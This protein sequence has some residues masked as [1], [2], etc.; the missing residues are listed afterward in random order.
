MRPVLFTS[1]AAP[2]APWLHP[3]ADSRQG[4]RAAGVPAPVEIDG[5]KPV[6]QPVPWQAL[7]WSG[8]SQQH[9]RGSLYSHS[10][11]TGAADRVQPAEQ[12]AGRVA[13]SCGLGAGAAAARLLQGIT[14]LAAQAAD[15]GSGSAGYW[16]SAEAGS[17]RPAAP[18]DGDAG[19]GPASR[20]TGY[21]S[22]LRGYTSSAPGLQDF[23][24]HAAD[25]GMQEQYA[26][27][28]RPAQPVRVV[29]LKAQSLHAG[30]D[31]LQRQQ[32][33]QAPWQLHGGHE[34]LTL[35]SQHGSN[36][37]GQQQAEA[38]A[39]VQQQGDGIM[40]QQRHQQQQQRQHWEVTLPRSPVKSPRKHPVGRR[41]AL[42]QRLKA[43]N[44]SKAAA[45]AGTEAGGGA[46]AGLHHD[47]AAQLIAQL[48]ELMQ[49]GVGVGQQGSTG[50]AAAP[51]AVTGSGGSRPD[52]DAAA[53]M[54][55]L[56]HLPS[57]PQGPAKQQVQS[58]EAQQ[59][60]QQQQQ[61][62]QGVE[63]PVFREGGSVSQQVPGV[64]SCHSQEQ[65]DAQASLHSAAAQTSEVLGPA[66]PA[67]AGAD[68]AVQAAGATVD[69]G[70]RPEQQQ[71]KRQQGALELAQ[72]ILD[73]LDQSGGVILPDAGANGSSMHTAGAGL[74]QGGTNSMPGGTLQVQGGDSWGLLPN[75]YAGAAAPCFQQVLDLQPEEM[76][77]CWHAPA[78][79][80]DEA[81]EASPE[82]TVMLQSATQ[83]QQQQWEQPAQQ[84]MVASSGGTP[85]HGC[86]FAACP[87]HIQSP[88][89]GESA[90]PQRSTGARRT[91]GTA[92]GSSRKPNAG[93]TKQQ[94]PPSRAGTGRAVTAVPILPRPKRSSTRSARQ[95]TASSSRV[96]ET[97]PEPAWSARPSLSASC[98]GEQQQQVGDSRQQL[99]P[100]T[101]VNERTKQL[102]ELWQ[103][104]HKQQVRAASAAGQQPPPV[105]GPDPNQQPLVDEQQRQEL[106]TAYARAAAARAAARKAAQH[107]ANSRSQRLRAE[108][109]D[110]GRMLA[111][112]DTLAAQMEVES[113]QA[114]AAVQQFEVDLVKRQ[115]VRAGVVG[116][117]SSSSLCVA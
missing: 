116:R 12:A 81:V 85:Q 20:G 3:T 78:A 87:R 24:Q 44:R 117:S 70:T 72:L 8:A 32:Q 90:N 53:A 43:I 58:E 99:S 112:V 2:A 95:T 27:P 36:A 68:A 15:G 69:A 74:S 23:V 66:E 105:Q 108:L 11:T 62:A 106:D 19:R 109:M 4:V 107:A 65:L 31:A 79:D 80:L 17:G 56:M 13:G 42:L 88:E 91:A 98:Q 28:A 61:L 82:K 22:G 96:S 76:Q 48:Q 64:A 92:A 29:V 9:P 39:N 47:P 5:S 71:L 6:Q 38:T 26:G 110:L 77:G 54:G 101:W 113:T 50:A 84:V 67:A 30:Q 93:S 16:L 102:D 94:Q 21:S 103:Q 51:A 115:S 60:Q 10:S 14:P 37:A 34:P 40:T 49:G 75:P 25:I 35:S 7:G 52:L 63:V 59:Q 104:W 73:A 46:A 97:Q 89:L 86:C 18:G 100:H 41:W 111:E 55:L 45:A 114:A 57:A 1:T 33:Q 83:Q